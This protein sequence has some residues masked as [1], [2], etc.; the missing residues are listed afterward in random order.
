MA[1]LILSM[2]EGACIAKPK[3]GLAEWRRYKSDGRAQ[4][5][6]ELPVLS[7]D[8]LCIMQRTPMQT[9]TIGSAHTI[10]HVMY[11]RLSRSSAFSIFP[12]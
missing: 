10:P 6:N 3:M 8:I 12:R 1:L 11:C 4:W 7:M 2:T 9:P 5:K